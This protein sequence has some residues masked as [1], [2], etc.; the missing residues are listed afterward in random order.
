MD[1][2]L[3]VVYIRDGYVDA[4]TA[5]NTITLADLTDDNASSGTVFWRS[6][7]NCLSV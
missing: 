4:F 6:R 2:D 3:A 5:M 7:S 1:A